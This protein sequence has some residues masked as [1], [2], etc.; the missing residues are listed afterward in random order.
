V[1]DQV[2]FGDEGN[3]NPPLD[4]YAKVDIRTS[5]NITEN[6]QIY[7]L[8]DNLFDSRYGIFGA[9]FNVE[10]A[11]R[12]ASADPELGDDFFDEDNPRSITPAPPITF[13]GGLKVKY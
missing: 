12:A 4:G 1:S 11:N 5:Y 2:F 13:Y 10:A 7:G 8:I 9:F 3:D 6:V